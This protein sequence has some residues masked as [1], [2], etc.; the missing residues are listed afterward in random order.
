LNLNTH[1]DAIYSVIEGKGFHTIQHTHLEA[2]TFRQLLHLLTEY[3]EMHEHYRSLMGKERGTGLAGL[4]EE[5]ADILIVALDLAG[6]HK[7][8]LFEVAVEGSPVGILEF[9]YAEIPLVIGRLGDE[10]RKERRLNATLLRRL[11]VVTCF[12]LRRHGAEPWAEVSKKMDKNRGRPTRYGLAEV[13][14]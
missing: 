2:L 6:M 13:T 1:R 9:L 3:G 14:A 11:I 12:I 10:Y 5:G 4:Y 8:D 7:I